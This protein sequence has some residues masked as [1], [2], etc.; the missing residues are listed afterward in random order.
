MGWE[1]FIS[2]YL[3]QLTIMITFGIRFTEFWYRFSGTDK[4]KV[5]MVSEALA[6]FEEYRVSILTEFL[7]YNVSELISFL[8]LVTVGNRFV[9]KINRTKPYYS[10]FYM[11]GTIIIIMVYTII[12]VVG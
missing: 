5:Y 3:G 11:D 6:R 2:Q 7:I 10:V 8:S 1:Q 4:K 12:K 9:C